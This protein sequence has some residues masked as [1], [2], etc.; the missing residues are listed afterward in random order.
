MFI[1]RTL[2]LL[3]LNKKTL[4]SRSITVETSVSGQKRF[5]KTVYLP[6]THDVL[7][8]LR[9][10]HLFRVWRE[11]EP[12][13][14]VTKTLKRLNGPSREFSCVFPVDPLGNCDQVTM[15][16]I[17]SVLLTTKIKGTDR[18]PKHLEVSI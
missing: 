17:E 14:L 1:R 6:N 10:L 13:D 3:H 16:L 9:V 4:V 15:E 11:N 2:P 18:Q 12:S 5:L 8:S 7:V